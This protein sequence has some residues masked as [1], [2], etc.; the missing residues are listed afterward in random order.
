MKYAPI[1]LFVYNRPE[2]TKKTIEHLMANAEFTESD[3]YVFSDGPR[4]DRDMSRIY[5][6]REMVRSFNLN[7]IVL[8]ERE[9]NFGLASSIISG[10][11]ELCERSGR[12][13]VVEDDLLVSPYFLDYMNRALD[14]YADNSKVMQVSGYIYPIKWNK[15]GG[16]TDAFF[17]PVTTSWG[18]ATW[19]R[20]WSK[21]DIEATGYKA[22]RND[23]KLRNKF[24]LNGAYP[25]FSMLKKQ[26]T[27]KVDSWAI[28]WYL[29][30]MLAQ[31]LV[32]FPRYSLVMNSGFDG[33]GTHCRAKKSSDRNELGNFV[34][35]K[36]PVDIKDDDFFSEYVGYVKKNNSLFRRVLRLFGV[37]E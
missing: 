30:V 28:R 17:M 24:N 34:P 27:G 23:I 5:A 3:F 21:F 32:L 7:N 33:S 9:K 8:V 10:I 26:R 19:Q 2:H 18:W 20:A 31:G 14:R 11:T 13:I 36:F 22:L 6:V 15:Q 12:V 16:E 35:V 4:N 1:T 37:D 25:Y 29:T